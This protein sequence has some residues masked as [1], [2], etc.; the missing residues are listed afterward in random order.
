MLG[1]FSFSDRAH[2]RDRLQQERYSV[3]FT[4]FIHRVR[5]G[6]EEFLPKEERA[7]NEVDP[8]ERR[9]EKGVKKLPETGSSRE[10]FGQEGA[11][12]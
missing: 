10:E 2:P 6:G 5:E 12:G 11:D 4:T 9:G 3:C 8:R 7:S 1:M